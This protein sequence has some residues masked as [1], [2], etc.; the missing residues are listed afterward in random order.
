[1]THEYLIAGI[2]CN[3]CVAK[4][5]SELLKMP[6][7]LNATVQQEQPQATITMS[8]HI[9]VAK[10]QHAIDKAGKFTISEAATLHHEAVDNE[11]ETFVYKPILL[12]L[13][14]MTG[15]TLLLQFVSGTFHFMQ[16]MQHFMAAFF[17]VFSFFKMLDLKGFADNYSTY[18]I[19]AKR[20]HA[21]GYLYAFIELLLGIAYLINFSPLLTNAITFLVM[22]ISIIGV[23]QSVLNKRAIKCA[24][25]GAI[26]NLPMSSI[27]II[28][29]AVMIVMSATMFGL[30]L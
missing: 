24:C 21:W 26:F 17:I 8:E 15:I 14:Y 29:D 3:N 16:W 22:S 12:V 30:M 6:A 7:V 4:I 9:S 1:M 20:W 28:E 2:T 27:T 18:D 13:T 23:L 10:L 11:K 5:K 25:L 19:V